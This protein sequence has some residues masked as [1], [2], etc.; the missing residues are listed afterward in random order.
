MPGMALTEMTP[1]DPLYSQQWHFA[2]LGDIETI[3]DEFDGSGVS[4]G[5][6]DDGIQYTHPDLAANYDASLHFTYLGVTYDG[7]ANDPDEV[8]GTAVAGIIAAQN[9]NGTGGTGVAHGAMLTSVNIFDPALTATRDIE[10]ASM[11]WAQNFD[12]MS[13]SWGWTPGYSG[14]QNL[15]NANSYHSQYQDWYGQNVANGR[16]GLGTIIVQAAGNDTLNANGD[17]V[18]A[19]RF[20]LSIAA[21]DES[22]DVKYYSNWG[23]CILVA[24]PAS[25][26]TTDRTGNDGYNGTADADPLPVNYTSDF[27]G[28]SAATPTVSGV[29]ALM[30]DANDDLGW[31]D[32]ADILAMS[33]ALTGSA[34]GGAGTGHEVGSWGSG[35]TTGWNGGGS[36]FHL[37]YGYGM[38]NAFA[39]VRMAEAWLTMHHDTAQTS[40]NEVTVTARHAGGAVAIPDY[41]GGVN[42]VAE[43][44]VVVGTDIEV[45]TIYVTVKVTHSYASDL[46]LS[47]VAPDGTE[48]P[49]FVNEGGSTLF[50]SGLRWTFAVEAARGYSSAG[51][52]AVRATDMAGADTGTINAVSLTFFGSA[53]SDDDVYHFTEDYLTLRA[54]DAGRG[55]VNDSNGGSDWLNMAALHGDIV[56]RLAG[57]STVSVD[58]VSWFDLAAG[59]RI[60]NFFAGDGNDTISGRNGASEI[61]G[62]RGNDLIQGL[63]GADVLV[64][65]QGND[66]LTGGT[67]ADSFEFSGAIGR[68]RIS[69]F[70]NDVDTLVLD[71]DLWGGGL[72]A[73]QVISGFAST[74]AAGVR[75]DFGAG[76]SILLAGLASAGLLVDDLAFL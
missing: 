63:G 72:T 27:G 47:L 41:A 10:R 18:N 25:A 14:F 56:A 24:A 16:D 15:S 5:V 4:V 64:G 2:L 12:I 68:D 38:V 32:V 34:Y 9:D 50:D 30:L 36:A 21:T 51:T 70:R 52:W 54:V 28:T 74:V 19:T 42:G 31:R 26:V 66:T 62:G 61:W 48:I 75:F 22:G 44:T 37:S 39:A 23:A 65:G 17:G 57:G 20:T 53:A 49:M 59:T 35:G 6:F 45:D 58:G 8:H 69:D 55:V 40:A 46:V 73:A 3:W 76:N 11:L 29:V 1:S 13:N 67:G 33:A 43:S 71:E 7:I 60:E